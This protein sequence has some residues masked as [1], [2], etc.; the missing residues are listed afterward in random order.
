MASGLRYA[1]K[2]ELEWYI[3]SLDHRQLFLVNVQGLVD[4]EIKENPSGAFVLLKVQEGID[5]SDLRSGTFE[6]AVEGMVFTTLSGE[7]VRARA[8]LEWI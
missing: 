7:R 3:V 5:P 4:V 1:T 2:E 8:K 6:E